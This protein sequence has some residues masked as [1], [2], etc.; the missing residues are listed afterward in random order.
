VQLSIGSDANT[1]LRIALTLFVLAVIVAAVFVSKRRS[2]AMGAE[3][4]TSEV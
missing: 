4:A 2:V 3:P 1:G